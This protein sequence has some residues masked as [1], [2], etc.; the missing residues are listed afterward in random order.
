[1]AGS[2]RFRCL[3]CHRCCR[4]QPGYVFLRESDVD[5]LAHFFK[6]RKEDFLRR[7]A[8]LVHGSDGPR[9]SLQEK[10]NFDCVFWHNG[11]QVYPARPLQCQVYPFWPRIVASSASWNSE[12][13]SCPGIGQG[14][15]YSATTVAEMVAR[16]ESSP[17]Y[18]PE[19]AAAKE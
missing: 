3:R 9:Y 11:C 12:A 14:Q 13:K 19:N 6:C 5:D 2:F 10:Y 18:R 15:S 4:H 1:M 8:R 17:Y 16:L 7:Y